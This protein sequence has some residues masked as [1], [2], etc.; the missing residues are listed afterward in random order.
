METKNGSGGSSIGDKGREYASLDK[1][2]GME[3]VPRQKT[4][5]KTGECD[6]TGVP[7]GLHPDVTCMD[8]YGDNS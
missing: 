1:G 2:G 6:K 3:T 7:R 8:D 5:G 4:M